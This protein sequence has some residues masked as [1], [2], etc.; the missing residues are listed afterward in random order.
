MKRYTQY[1]DQSLQRGLLAPHGLVLA[2][3]V[4]FRG[5]VARRSWAGA[6]ESGGRLGKIAE[7]LHRLGIPHGC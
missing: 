3:N 5:R 6:P 4:L 2:D 1:L 7:S